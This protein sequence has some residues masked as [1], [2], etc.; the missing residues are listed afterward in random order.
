VILQQCNTRFEGAVQ[1]DLE[2]SS[3]GSNVS[4]GFDYAA[5]AASSVLTDGYRLQSQ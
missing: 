1:L 3:L 4:F 2:S 5:P